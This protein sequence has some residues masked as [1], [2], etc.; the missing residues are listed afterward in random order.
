MSIVG[1]LMGVA[2]RLEFRGRNRL[3]SHLAHA[4]PALQSWPVAI[5]DSSALHVDLRD[6]A[7]VAMCFDREIPHERGL[8]KILT[9]LLRPGDTFWD[10]GANLGY[11]SAVFSEPHFELREVH[12]FEPN[13]SL[14]PLLKRSLGSRDSVTVHPFA[15]GRQAGRI[16]LHIPRSGGL[17]ISGLASLRASARGRAIPVDVRTADEVIA[18]GAAP[19]DVMK[20]DVEGW[21]LHVLAGYEGM[22]QKRP[23][24]ALEWIDEVA[25]QAG[26]TWQDLE[27]TF[28]GWKIFRVENDGS[29]RT[30]DI[31]TP[32]SGNDLVVIHES[33]DRMPI[34]AGLVR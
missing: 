27:R 25:G 30:T 32:K 28:A 11:Y 24:V 8:R 10:V 15:L 14:V 22:R 31:R 5:S 33:S 29:L 23:V 2:D 16:G 4:V 21:E 9:A 13:P 12:C 1:S 34:A 3:I 7:N 19:P 26:L 20:I 17:P 18:N 6:I